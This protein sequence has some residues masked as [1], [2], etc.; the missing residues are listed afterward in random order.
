[1]AT[2]YEKSY[3][4]EDGETVVCAGIMHK[5]KA[6]AWFVVLVLGLVLTTLGIILIIF[7]V[8]I[9]FYRILVSNWKLFLTSTDIH[10]KYGNDDVII[11]LSEVKQIEVKPRSQHTIVVT[12]K[13][14][15][16]SSV[17]HRVSDQQATT[18][19]LLHTLNSKE[20][21][22]AVEREMSR[23]EQF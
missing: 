6:V 17:S 9:I 4:S 11:P 22:A 5:K 21:V 8:F 19:K 14:P 15:M 12:L 2:S 18:I 16:L 3:L 20:F 13:R 10:Y 23:M 7:P 1:M